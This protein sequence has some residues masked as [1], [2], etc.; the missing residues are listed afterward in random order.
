MDL[1]TWIE[2]HAAFQP[3][4]VAIRFE[5]QAIDYAALAW[6][7]GRCAGVLASSGVGVG[8]RVAY[9]GLNRP[10]MIELAFACA[11]LGAMLV[12]LNWRLAPPEHAYILDNA[13]PR[14][15]VMEA[16]LRAGLDSV[17]PAVKRIVLG[18]GLQAW[19]DGVDA[20]A[21]GNAESPILIVYTSGTTGRPKGAVLTQD[22]LL[23]NALN[24][25]HAHDL[26]S[27]DRVL[28]VLP[29]FHVGGL[30]IQTLPALHAGAEVVLHRRF[31]PA[32]TLASIAADRPSLVVLVPATIAAMIEHPRWQATNL[33]SLR[34]VTTGSSIVPA[35]LIQA[36]HERGVPVI[37]VYGSTE[38]API[39]VYLR[40]EQ[41]RAHMGSTG[42]PGLHCEAG[43]R[44]ADGGEAAPGARG[45]I[46]VRGRNVM[47]EYWRDPAATAEALAGGWFHTGDIGHRDAE[48]FFYVDE[49]KK[50]VIISGGENVYPAE[51]EE[52][53]L[54]DPEVA[55]AAV[56]ARPH[57]RWGE[58]PVAVVVARPGAAPAPKA[59]LQRFDGRLARF[60][61]PRDVVFVERLPRNAMGKVLRHELRAMLAGAERAGG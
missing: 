4:K 52:V 35:L 34:M 57:P 24:S 61:H 1:S 36:F 55:E 38:T 37:Q 46:L 51:L 47:R 3:R 5:D 41:A 21:A 2:R 27:G 48:G 20:P 17:L 49:R 8:D 60:K 59:I 58:E 23:C 16:A 12:P 53:L 10:E 7:I 31:D 28:T 30:N 25:V 56:V 13:A 39:A 42:L 29:M 11:R 6:R 54:E 18:A 19:P 45:E 9:L 22:A 43:I 26:A 50:D 14:L 44:A 33:S 15:I 40:A 32:A